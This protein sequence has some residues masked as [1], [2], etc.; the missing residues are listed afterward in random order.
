MKARGAKMRE[1]R[2][3]VQIFVEEKEN[4]FVSGT[5]KPPFLFEILSSTSKVNPKIVSNAQPRAT[6]QNRR[7]TG[8]NVGCR[9]ETV[10]GVGMR[11]TELRKLW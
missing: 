11:P 4:I 10:P 8:S 9:F 2:K 3:D 5:S 7:G 6:T 1:G